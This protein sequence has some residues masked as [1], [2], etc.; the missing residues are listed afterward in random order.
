MRL[1]VVLLDMEKKFADAGVARQ[2]K[3]GGFMDPAFA[4]RIRT[5]E[6]RDDLAL[7]SDADWILEAVAEKL[8]IKQSLYHAVDGVRKAGS[9]VSSTPRPFPCKR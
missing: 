4:Q 1:D 6:T 3:A 2:L 8:E 9:I 5:G 7:L